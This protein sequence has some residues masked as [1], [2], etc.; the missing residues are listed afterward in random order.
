MDALAAA[1]TDEAQGA[2]AAL[3]TDAKLDAD[4]RIAAA[5][6]LIRVQRP[7]PRTIDT[8][9][10]LIPDPLLREHAVFGLGTAARR[11]REAGDAARSREILGA[12]GRVAARR[13]ADGRS[14]PLP[15]RHRQLGVQRGAAGGAAVR[16]GPRRQP[17]RRRD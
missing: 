12:A 10:Q 6:S 7:G 11:L 13:E 8:L 4:A 5:N 2:L 9:T 14:D 3:V 17:A 15:A 1:G 16:V